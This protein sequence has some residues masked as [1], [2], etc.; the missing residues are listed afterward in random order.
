MVR[1]V[2]LEPTTPRLKIVCSTT[3]L[4]TLVVRGRDLH[5]TR[6]VLI[7][8][9][10]LLIPTVLPRHWDLLMSTYSITLTALIVSYIDNPLTSHRQQS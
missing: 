6:S 10:T 5:P 2:G 3:E 9:V 7:G 4:Q 8:Y 1:L